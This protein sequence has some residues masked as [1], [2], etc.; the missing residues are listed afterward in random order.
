MRAITYQG[1]LAFDSNHPD[2]IAA[3]GECLVRVRM[4]GV[5]ATDQ[6]ILKGYLGF[7]GVLGHEM[8]GTVVAGSRAW[9][10]KRVACEINCV[11]R[12][13]DMCQSGLSNHCRKRTVMGIVGRD[14]CFA[15]YVAVPERNLHTLPDTISDEEAIFV[16]PLAAAY[17]VLSQVPI[18]ARTSVVVLGSGRLGLL[19]A[20]VV[21][22]TGCKPAV[23]GRNREKLLVCEKRGIQAFHV[24]EFVPRHDR[25]VVVECTG[26]TEGLGTALRMVR[27]R[28]TIVLKSTCSEPTKVDLS[29]LVVDE[30]RLV[31]SRCGPFSE[32]ISALARHAVDVRCMISRVVSI[33]QGVEAFAI[34][35]RPEVLGVLFKINSR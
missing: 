15:D 2:P 9:E 35:T 23:I 12:S 10:G 27:P 4:A 22:A 14:G 34:A 18:D 28:G 17:Q 32:A 11:C 30:V 25:D 33:E 1:K 19:V 21:L 7:R 6:Q 8:V 26:S 31:G 3:E 13:C 16:E 5:C 20:Q 24:D 29:P